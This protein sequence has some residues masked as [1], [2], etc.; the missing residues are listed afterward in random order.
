MLGVDLKPTRSALM[1]RRNIPASIFFILCFNAYY[2]FTHDCY[3]HNFSDLSKLKS[4]VRRGS[5]A[6]AETGT[7]TQHP[8]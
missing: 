6:G 7:I 5:V 2:F 8:P 4:G 3:G 1:T